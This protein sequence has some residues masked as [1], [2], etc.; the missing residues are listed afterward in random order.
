MS[1]KNDERAHRRELVEITNSWGDRPYAPLLGRAVVFLSGLIVLG[2]ATIELAAPLPMPE[3]TG[4]EAE[5]LE[6]RRAEASLWDGTLA[7]SMEED[8]AMT[9]PVRR[10][11]G[12]RVGRFLLDHFD[13]ATGSVLI[14]PRG[15]MF[16]GVRLDYQTEVPERA[17][18]RL[19]VSIR[20]LERRL[21]SQ[22]TR[23][24]SVILPRKAVVAERQ[25][26]FGVDPRAELDEAFTP[27][28]G[29][30]GIDFVDL[31]GP[32]REWDGVPLF[33]ATDTHW[34]T[35]G[36]R[37]GAETITRRSGLLVDR[38]ERL[39]QILEID[40][41]TDPSTGDLVRRLGI[42]L[43]RSDP[44]NFDKGTIAFPHP[45]IMTKD[46]ETLRRHWALTGTSYS[47]NKL[48]PL[49]GHYAAQP[50]IT[51]AFGGLDTGYALDQLL[52]TV[53]PPEPGGTE[54]RWLPE[55][56]FAEFP[57]YQA[58]NRAKRAAPWAP[59]PG[60]WSSI[61]RVPPRRWTAIDT[62]GEVL[63]RGLERGEP[64]DL[65]GGRALVEL[66]EGS[67]LRDGDGTLEV[68]LDIELI[69]GSGR[70][71]VEVGPMR[72]TMPLEPGRERLV[73]PLLSERDGALRARVLLATDSQL[74]AAIHDAET[75]VT[76]ETIR[77]S[78]VASSRVAPRTIERFD[79]LLVEG[80]GSAP[81]TVILEGANGR[82]LRRWTRPGGP[83][84]GPSVLSLGALVGQRL[85]SVRVIG[86][87]AEQARL[88][89]IAIPSDRE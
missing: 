27:Q 39:G 31:L 40:R 50:T 29:S 41:W 42:E 45:P 89:L 78:S 36:M 82:E 68:A 64:F 20:P 59:S 19:G 43:D 85:E 60:L 8:I 1:P 54:E 15:W 33:R 9:S 21:A 74:R 4:R 88:G 51:F 81:A 79:V 6:R 83:A 80:L 18:R 86:A 16:D 23:L 46:P 11:I 57:T 71:I 37:L 22:G 63:S 70:V 87:E 30:I 32:F 66:A 69:E 35:D 49:L 65:V 5:D 34:N 53:T 58:M 52:R 48:G 14:G 17:A 28:L 55:V 61:R 38:S 77:D 24:I 47:M 3:L 44:R 56:V 62:G 10:E 76:G 73:L 2:T 75:G 26:P 25:L 7:R 72:V 13:E 12:R 84:A 67:I